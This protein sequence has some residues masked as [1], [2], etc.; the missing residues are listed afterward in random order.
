ML[1]GGPD[2]VANLADAAVRQGPGWEAYPG[3]AGSVYGTRPVGD[4]NGDGCS[5]I[6]WGGELVL[7]GPNGMEATGVLPGMNAQIRFGPSDLDGDGYDDMVALGQ[8]SDGVWLGNADGVPVQDFNWFMYGEVDVRDITGDG[9]PDALSTVGDHVNPAASIPEEPGFY[10]AIYGGTDAG[11][12]TPMPSDDD[13]PLMVQSVDPWLYDSFAGALDTVT[14]V[15][16]DFDR[17]QFG[18]A[19]GSFGDIDGDGYR[20]YLVMGSPFGFVYRG[21]SRLERQKAE[22]DGLVNVS[23]SGIPVSWAGIMTDVRRLNEI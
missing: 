4:V 1:Y 13:E 11:H 3:G 12:A 20:D 7:G 6:V 18:E 15:N 10:Y 19:Q 2:P 22:A 9:V 21:G 23:R 14:D 17:F 8:T 5:D 16:L